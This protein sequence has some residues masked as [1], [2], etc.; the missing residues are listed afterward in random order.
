MTTGPAA[1]FK[2]NLKFWNPNCQIS[3]FKRTPRV[4][5]VSPG[6]KTDCKMTAQVP[7][8][9]LAEK[10]DRAAQSLG[11]KIEKNAKFDCFSSR[12]TKRPSGRPRKKFPDF[13]F[14]S[15]EMLWGD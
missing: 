14:F 6:A 5:Q 9:D 7:S 13:C 8:F 10:I 11:G 3:N 1:G 4:L 2:T 15:G 12:E